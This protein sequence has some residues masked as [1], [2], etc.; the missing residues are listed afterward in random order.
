MIY[1][2][3]YKMTRKLHTSKFLSNRFSV[4]STFLTIN[5]LSTSSTECVINGRQLNITKRKF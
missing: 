5:S 1:Y 2:I 3:D 4:K